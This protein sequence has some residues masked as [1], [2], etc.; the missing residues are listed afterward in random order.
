MYVSLALLLLSLLTLVVARF[1]AKQ[2]T[3]NASTLM[4]T[5]LLIVSLINLVIVA[6]SFIMHYSKGK[7]TIINITNITIHVLVLATM[8]I[9]YFMNRSKSSGLS[10]GMVIVSTLLFLASIPMTL[11]Y[12]FSDKPNDTSTDKDNKD[13]L[14]QVDRTLPIEQV[15]STNFDAMELLKQMQKRADQL[16]SR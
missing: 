4:L 13:T 11:L 5:I 14:I 7:N 8:I 3:P 16:A 10:N 9:T 6:G 12:L 2:N 15:P 1:T